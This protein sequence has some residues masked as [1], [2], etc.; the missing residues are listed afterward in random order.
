MLDGHVYVRDGLRLDTLCRIDHQEGALTGGDGTRHLVGEI[1]V[2]RS[3]DQVERVVLPLILVSHLDGMAL[4]GDASFPLKVHAVEHL[5]LEV[6]SLHG[7]GELQQS[8]GQG[9]LPMVNMGDDTKIAY[10]I[11]L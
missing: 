3:V 6:L 4:D 7:L 8:V 11:H 2:P 10:L 1:H 9:A 5:C